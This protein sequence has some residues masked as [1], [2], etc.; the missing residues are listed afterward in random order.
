MKNQKGFAPLIIILVI[1]LGIGGVY[2][3]GKL[4]PNESVDTTSPIATVSSLPV[5]TPTPETVS[6]SVNAVVLNYLL[7]SGWQTTTDST[8]TFKVGFDPATQ[9]AKNENGTLGITNKNL[10]NNQYYSPYG[11]SMN[12]SIK[13]YNGGSRHEFI[14]KM[15]GENP[16]ETDSLMDNYKEYN[17]TIDGKSCL[18]LD[19]ISISQ[20]PTVWGM[21]AINS[22]QVLSFSMFQ[23]FSYL[24]TLKTIEFLK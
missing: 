1:L 14:Y 2:Y 8:N 7:P 15:I 12:F 5:A 20:Y 22:S 19:G 21:C 10:D 24:S 17:Y 11:N 18:I 13:Q 3:F 16:H 6:A 23:H 4:S 9:D